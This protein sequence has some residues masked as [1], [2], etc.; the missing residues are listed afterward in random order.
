[1]TVLLLIY[2]YAFQNSLGGDYGMA[3]ALSLM[4]AA[5]LAVFT[6]GYFWLTRS[7]ERRLV[8]AARRGVAPRR[9]ERATPR[10]RRSCRRPTGASAASRWSMRLLHVA[11]LVFLLI[12]GLGPILWMA[13]SA[14]TPTQDTLR[15]P[16]ALWPHGFD[17]AQPRDGLER[18]S[19]STATCS[20]RSS[21]R[22][23]RGWSRSWSR[24]RPATRCRC[25]RPRVRAA[26]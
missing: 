14:I 20:T 10:A 22:S 6:A 24:R 23:G 25:L 21:S 9:R 13:K 19:T 3:A 11:M 26:S 16:M 17:L 8:T 12:V 2:K 18:G 5:F 7:L 4:L 15:T 1:M